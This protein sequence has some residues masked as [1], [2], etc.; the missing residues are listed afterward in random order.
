MPRSNDARR[1]ALY[2]QYAANLKLVKANTIFN[3]GIEPDIPDTILC[4]MC[5]TLFARKHLD[6]DQ[7]ITFDHNP[8]TAMGG[9]A[10]SG[11][12]L[13]GPCNH[14]LGSE[15]DAHLIRTLELGAF[16][17]GVTGAEVR[18]KLTFT[19]LPPLAV[20]YSNSASDSLA[21]RVANKATNPAWLQPLEE[22]FMSRTKADV[23]SGTISVRGGRK[24]R[25]SLALLRIGYLQL[26]QLFGYG[27]LLMPPYF[28]IRQQ[29]HEPDEPHLDS[30]WNLPPFFTTNLA[31]GVH[32]FEIDEQI[33][34][35]AV[36]FQL[37]RNQRTTR[38]AIALPT[39]EADVKS[40]YA[41]LGAL[42]LDP[43][44]RQIRAKPIESRI[45]LWT[46]PVGCMASLYHSFPH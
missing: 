7:Y 13:C 38:H 11:V 20:S 14:R 26:F 19:G 25:S 5:L 29:L 34:G 42:A 22:L 3:V 44:P 1:R 4:P 24:T 15:L 21:I 33:R 43:V 6:E 9:K 32:L 45:E 39:V 18:G 36:A 23:L 37:R 17:Q 31:D 10:E 16:A 27:L 40:F 28:A 8:P 46:D 35:F 41:Q 2:D 12:L 30:A